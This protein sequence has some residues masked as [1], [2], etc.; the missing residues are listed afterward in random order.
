[1][2]QRTCWISLFTLETWSELAQIDYVTTGFPAKH[3]RRA[4][5]IRPGDLFLCYMT[6]RSRFIGVLEILSEFYWDETPIWTS[7]VFPVRFKTRLVKKVHEDSG[8]HLHEVVAQSKHARS[9]SGYYR[10]A[11]LRL[12][13]ADAE[14]IIRRL[15]AIGD[16]VPQPRE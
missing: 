10:S 5:K 1:M 2:P 13:D 11:P 12:P 14:F 16:D 8:I 15:Q 6:G 9:W 4:G 7:D 3:E